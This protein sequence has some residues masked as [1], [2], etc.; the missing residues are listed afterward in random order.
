MARLYPVPTHRPRRWVALVCVA[1]PLGLAL[2]WLLR[3]APPDAVVVRPPAAVQ[4]AGRFVAPATVPTDASC[5]AR[6][7]VARV[8]GP[9]TSACAAAVE[10]LAGFGVRWLDGGAASPKFDQFAWLQVARGTVTL[11]GGRAEFRN[12]AGAY[13]PVEYGCDFDPKTLA[14]LEARARPRSPSL[15]PVQTGAAAR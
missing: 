1:V 9:A 6:C 8:I 13:L 12:A 14:V 3:P 5:D 10:E 2:A 11:A 15:Q 7:A 4:A